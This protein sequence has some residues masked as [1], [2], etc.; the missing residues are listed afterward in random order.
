[1]TVQLVLWIRWRA[2]SHERA[3]RWG[4][5][6]AARFTR[7]VSPAA[8]LRTCCSLSSIKDINKSI[9]CHKDGAQLVKMTLKIVNHKNTIFFFIIVEF[10]TQETNVY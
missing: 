5:T 7:Q 3:L 2:G 8:Q 9:R 10:I 1:M 4:E 6:L